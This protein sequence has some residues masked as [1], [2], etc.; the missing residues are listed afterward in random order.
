MTENPLIVA[1]VAGEHDADLDQ[2]DL[3]IRNRKRRMFRPGTKVR[4]HGTRNASIDG[5]TGVILK[6]NAKR[7]TVGL[8]EKDQF[9]YEKEFLIPA[10]MLEVIP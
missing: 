10:S 5:M 9:G 6:V 7:M 8:G 4:L 2:I 3:A 1:I